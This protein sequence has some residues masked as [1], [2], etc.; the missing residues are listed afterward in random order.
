MPRNYPQGKCFNF[1]S[2]FGFTRDFC[3]IFLDLFTKIQNEKQGAEAIDI[4]TESLRL[5]LQP[6]KRYIPN[7]DTQWVNPTHP[8]FQ[9][10]MVN[11]FPLTNFSLKKSPLLISKQSSATPKFYKLWGRIDESL[12]AGI[13]SVTLLNSKLSI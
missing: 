5:V 12:S 3:W 4:D 9:N 6:P 1:F 11:N 2:K 7:P 10:W 13:Y 8:R